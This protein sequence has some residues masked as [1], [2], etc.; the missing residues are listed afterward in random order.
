MLTATAELSVTDNEVFANNYSITLNV[1]LDSLVAAF[2][3]GTGF[4]VV[5][6]TELVVDAAS[7]YDLVDLSMDGFS[8]TFSCVDANTPSQFCFATQTSAELAAVDCFDGAAHS[9]LDTESFAYRTVGYAVDQVELDTLR[10]SSGS[11]CLMSRVGAEGT[12]SSLYMSTLSTGTYTLS[13][14]ISKD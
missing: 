10:L 4:T 9:E 3:G 8:F 13:V 5:T 12:F 11:F 2:F 14:N 1:E 7:S 6:G